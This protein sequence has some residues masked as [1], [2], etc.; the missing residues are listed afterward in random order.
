MNLRRSTLN[1]Q[2]SQNLLVCVLCGFSMFCVDLCLGAAG[3]PQQTVA[4]AA[5]P[6]LLGRALLD[7]YCVT[8]HNQPL[9]TANITFDTMDLAQLPSHADVSEKVVRKLTGALL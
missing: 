7:Q 2:N 5:A 8:C 4:P 9:K 6:K 3:V 1:S